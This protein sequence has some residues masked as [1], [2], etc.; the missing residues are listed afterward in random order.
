MNNQAYLFMMF[1]VNGVLI[2]ILFDV[3]RILRK[4]FKTKDV[5]TYIEDISFWILTG[6]L[7]L[8][9]VFYYNDGEIRFYIFLGIILGILIYILTISKYIIKFS[10]TII[11]F[12]KGIINKVIKFVVYPLKLIINFIKKILFRPISFI[13]INIRKY[14]TKNNTYLINMF[15]KTNKTTKSEQ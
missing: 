6:L 12:V 5:I 7:T 10:V 13:F 3:F 2:G 4:T 11:N 8:Y 15:K 9:F 1:I 14:F